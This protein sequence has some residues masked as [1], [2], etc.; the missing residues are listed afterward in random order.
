MNDLYRR[1][2]PVA[3]PYRSSAATTIQICIHRIE[4]LL[5]EEMLRL[6]QGARDELERTNIRKSH[7][8]EEFERL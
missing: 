5:D 2:G 1:I 8:P 6:D 3:S 4:D 7:L